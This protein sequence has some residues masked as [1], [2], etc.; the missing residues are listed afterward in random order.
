VAANA[1]L[2]SIDRLADESVRSACNAGFRVL[3]LKVGV[4]SID[5]EIKHLQPYAG[6]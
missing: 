6:W 5:H 3:K 2:G 4:A 1:G